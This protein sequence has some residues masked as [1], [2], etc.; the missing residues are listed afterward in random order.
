MSSE[1]LVDR[2]PSSPR[3][4][5]KQVIRSGA[6][7]TLLLISQVYLPDPASV[8]QHMSDVAEEMVNRGYRV[9]VITADR[10]YDDPSCRYLSREVYAGVEIR[11]IGLSSFG[12]HRFPLRVLAAILFT[13][14][15]A[16]IGLAMPGLSLVLVSTSRGSRRPLRLLGDGPEPGPARGSGIAASE[17]PLDPAAGKT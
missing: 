1:R 2:E 3:P 16:L 13:L 7:K 12:K 17:W 5:H 15:A 8:G 11:R 4:E 9:I 14:Q 6:A 10:G